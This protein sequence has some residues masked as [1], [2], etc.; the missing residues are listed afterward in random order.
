MTVNTR[1]QW[2]RANNNRVVIPRKA[3]VYTGRKLVGPHIQTDG[4]SDKE[5]SKAALRG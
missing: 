3:C 5:R 4:D 2:S 1:K